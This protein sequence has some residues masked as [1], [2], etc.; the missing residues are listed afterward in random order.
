MRTPG[1]LT[2]M[3]DDQ[4]QGR[5]AMPRGSFK[6]SFKRVLAGTAQEQRAGIVGLN[7]FFG[8]LLGANLG[9]IGTLGLN[10]YVGLVILLAAFVSSMFVLLTSR[11]KYVVVSSL[12]GMAVA[13][14]AVFVDPDFR[15]DG[16]EDEI[17][18]IVATLLVWL[19]FVASMRLMPVVDDPEVPVA[20]APIRADDEL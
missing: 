5:E 10:E 4:D 9:T 8:A 17:Q 16:M 15:P 1:R 7:L 12:F 6:N 18:R 3:A 13:L 2:T 11:R 19:G 20:P 14:A